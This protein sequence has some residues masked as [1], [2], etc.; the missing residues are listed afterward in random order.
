VRALH[1]HRATF[2][3]PFRPGDTMAL[4]AQVVAGDALAVVA[5]GQA[6][7]N[8]TLAAF[9]ISELYLDE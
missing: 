9:A 1:I 6:W 2:L 8:G 7:N 3:A 5:A 4:H